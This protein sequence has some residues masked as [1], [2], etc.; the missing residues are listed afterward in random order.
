MTSKAPTLEEIG[1][2]KL[3]TWAICPIV[4]GDFDCTTEDE[5]QLI[6]NF[7]IDFESDGWKEITFEFPDTDAATYWSHGNDLQ[8]N[9]GGDV[10][11]VTVYGVKS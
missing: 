2:Y 6:E 9:M 7:Y 10:V 11:D 8:R 3:P 4:D 5:D 1:T